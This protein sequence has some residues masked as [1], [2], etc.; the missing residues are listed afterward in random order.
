[1]NEIAQKNPNF[2]LVYPV[3]LNPNVIKPVYQI[4]SGIKNIKLIEPL[5]Y[6][7]FVKLMN[8]AYLVL[9]DSATG[10]AS[11]LFGTHGT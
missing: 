8:S 1:M 10:T 2:E 11:G 9:T 4:L 7:P 3:H 6:K 5:Q